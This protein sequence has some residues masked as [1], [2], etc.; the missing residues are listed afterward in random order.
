MHIALRE[1]AEYITRLQ[2]TKTGKGFLID[3]LRGYVEAN[4][5]VMKCV[6]SR[7]CHLLTIKYSIFISFY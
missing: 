5:G 2:K 3:H 1:N 7:E 6:S 4:G